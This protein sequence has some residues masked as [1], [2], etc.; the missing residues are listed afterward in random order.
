VDS[1]NTGFMPLSQKRPDIT[2]VQAVQWQLRNHDGFVHS[3][4]SSIRF[5][6]ITAQQEN[7]RRLKAARDDEVLLITGTRDPIIFPSEVREDAEEL[8]GKDRVVFVELDSTHDF[9]ITDS[10]D[11]VS[12]IFMFWKS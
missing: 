9:P 1:S 12:A 3:F 6:P 4:L 2:V 8:L 10:R 7:W 11:V 5:A